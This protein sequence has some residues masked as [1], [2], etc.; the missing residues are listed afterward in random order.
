MGYVV[1]AEIL[2]A[3]AGILVSDLADERALTRWP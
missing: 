3:V 1:L 2:A